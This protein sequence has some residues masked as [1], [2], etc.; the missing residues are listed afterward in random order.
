MTENVPSSA[1]RHETLRMRSEKGRHLLLRAKARPVSSGKVSSVKKGG[2]H[3]MASNEVADWYVRISWQMQLTRLLKGL[4]AMFS[5]AWLMACSSMSMPSTCA[6]GFLWADMRAMSPVPVPISRI[7]LPSTQPH[8]PSRTPSVPT[9][10]AQ[11]SW[12]MLN[13]LKRK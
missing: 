6:T 2:L 9:F 4:R 5:R 12:W 11:R 7:R 10:I 1:R 3:R 8:A 13:C